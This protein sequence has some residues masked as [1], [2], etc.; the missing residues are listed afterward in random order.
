MRALR[1]GAVAAAFVVCGAVQAAAVADAA[2]RAS[3]GANR[4][5]AAGSATT[6]PAAT[7]ATAV[8]AATAAADPEVMRTFAQGRVAYRRDGS[9]VVEP[10]G[11]AWPALAALAPGSF[12]AAI[13]YLHGCDGIHGLALKTADLLAAA[14]Y[15]VVLPDSHAR[16]D[17]PPSCDPLARRGGFHRGV[18]AWRHAEA[19]RA[20]KE[21][22]RLPAAAGAP[23]LL[24]GLSEG[25]IAAATYR[26]E[27]LR[28]RVV[29][30]WTCHAGWPE[31][32]GLRAAADEAVLTL[33]SEN[34]PWFQDPALRGDC[35]EF[36][37]PAT[38]L[39]QSIVYRAPHPAA[40]HHD[41]MWNADARRAV[42]DFLE[43]ASAV[44]R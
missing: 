28:G 24:F 31:Y 2:V 43:R 40:P 8:A 5:S 33:T 16:L 44:A 12:R 35:S 17:K 29:E 19:D 26:D 32:R 13:V 14:G 23:V 25:A 37:G 6:A 4:A 18:L 36:L 10:V 41:L 34:D 22:R 20:L 9:V 3:S 39:R 15:L 7:T 30:A 27:P 21:L 42:L 1:A 11:I 38:P